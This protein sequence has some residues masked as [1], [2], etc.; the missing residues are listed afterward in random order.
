MKYL[1]IA[2]LD[3]SDRFAVLDLYLRRVEARSDVIVQ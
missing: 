3:V 2:R 1:Y